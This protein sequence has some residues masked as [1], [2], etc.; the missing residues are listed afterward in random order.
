LFF[1]SKEEREEVI[2]DLKA[3]GM[4]VVYRPISITPDC[5]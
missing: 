4:T 2:K 1:D 3:H 5:S